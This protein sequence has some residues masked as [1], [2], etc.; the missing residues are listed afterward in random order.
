MQNVGPLPRPPEF[1]STEF[2]C[3]LSWKSPNLKHC[4]HLR[5]FSHDTIIV[6]VCLWLNAVKNSI[7]CFLFLICLFFYQKIINSE[8][9]L[10]CLLESN[11]LIKTIISQLPPFMIC[12]I[13]SIA[14]TES[15][16]KWYL[17]MSERKK[18]INW[19]G[20]FGKEN[21]VIETSLEWVQEDLHLMTSSNQPHTLRQAP[22]HFWAFGF[23]ICIKEF[24]QYNPQGSSP[25]WALV[26]TLL[27]LPF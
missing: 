26:G 11:H 5:Y 21:I 25:R 18:K 22:S 6:L 10:H 27:I 24:G 7:L 16:P 2:V 15:P 8:R 20:R 1:R 4:M 19:S 14:R 13:T 12:L 9:S 3:L 23:F 17:L